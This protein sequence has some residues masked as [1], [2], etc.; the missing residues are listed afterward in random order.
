MVTASLSQYWGA[1]SQRARPLVSHQL[2]CCS[3][4]LVSSPSILSPRL[5]HHKGV[6][7]SDVRL[8]GSQQF[9]RHSPRLGGLLEEVWQPR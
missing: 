5:T 1:V 2:S 6:D 7:L 4:K 3:L 8:N 9:A